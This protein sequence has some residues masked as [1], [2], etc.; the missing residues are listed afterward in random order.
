MPVAQQPM[1]SSLTEHKFPE[2]VHA[3]YGPVASTPSVSAYIAVYGARLGV[4]TGAEAR[5]DVHQVT[6][7]AP[8]DPRAVRM[9][10]SRCNSWHR[11]STTQPDLLCLLRAAGLIVMGGI[12]DA[13]SS[14][15]GTTAPSGP[16]RSASFVD[17]PSLN[18]EFCR[19]GAEPLL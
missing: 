11:N 16:N 2:K 6:R 1:G 3:I 13:N 19:P 17:C 7:T 4:L 18:P 9:L 12:V 10:S 14:A 5:S 8:V 15:A